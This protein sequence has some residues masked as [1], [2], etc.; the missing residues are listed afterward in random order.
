MTAYDMTDFHARADSVLRPLGIV[1]SMKA[2]RTLSEALWLICEQEDRLEAV[3]KEL[4]D[5]I[6]ERQ[7]CNWTAIQSAIRRAAQTAWNTNPEQ[8]QRL[9]GYPLTGCP[10]AV[11]FLEMLYNSLVRSDQR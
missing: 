7:H 3:K 6:A 8:V 2:Y 11:Q 1:R 5:P 10:S 9:A 4:Y